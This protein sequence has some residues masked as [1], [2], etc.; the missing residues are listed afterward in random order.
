MPKR[1][2]TFGL[3]TFNL[4]ETMKH[5][6]L[7][8]DDDSFF[9]K[10]IKDDFSSDYF[11]CEIARNVAQARVLC[12]HTS[13]DVVLLDNNLPDG[14]G[15]DIVPDILRV[16]D[17]AKIILVTAFPTFDSAVQALKKGAYDYVS[18]PVELDELKL[19]IERALRTSDLEAVEQVA[20]YER[21][22]E[23]EQSNIIGTGKDF[24]D[25]K[26]LVF[27]AANSGA[28][29]L[30]TGET[31]TGKNVVAKAIHHHG[32]NK[33]APFIAV[34][35]AALPESLIEAEL[36]GVEK[37]AFTG[38]TNTRKGTFELA[39]G[40]TLFLDE[41]G[42][43]P[44]A[45]QA[46]LLSALE[47]RLIRRIGGEQFRAVNV[48]IIAATNA[49]PEK[50]IAEKRFRQDLFYRLSVIQIHLKPLREQRASIPVLAKHF[51]EQLAPNR[52]VEIS[53]AE[54]DFL[55]SYDFRGNVR[56]LRNIVERSL[57]M[58]AGREIFPSQIVD[59]KPQAA[60]V[61][62]NQNMTL[63]ESEKQII[64]NKFN[65]NNN[66]LAR[67]AIALDISLSTLK[68]KLREYGMR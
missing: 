44:I 8:V 47:D 40:G 31:G 53:A 7:I 38:A 13:F 41:I 60:F 19:S 25:V 9:A 33:N 10:V 20:V 61:E 67:T 22:K 30:I 55:Q 27:R 54:L 28:S 34:N 29:V 50:A 18:K 63:A 49:E 12:A 35:C 3:A 64:L 26:E 36:F 68:R 21:A 51:I 32:S 14:G 23:R 46:K 59:Y 4:Y 37:G 16:N 42:E 66:N 5:N 62:T 15:L 43:M 6:L 56:E 39:D 52:S 11:N 2:W 48:R 1:F 57:I 17:R 58:G 65:F 45:L 24:D